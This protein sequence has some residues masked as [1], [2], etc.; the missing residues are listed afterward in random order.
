MK[1]LVTTILIGLISLLGSAQKVLERTI[2]CNKQALVFDLKFATEIEVK[3]CD[4]SSIYLKAEIAM[5]EEKYQ[6]MFQ[7]KVDERSSIIEIS[8]NSEAIFKKIWEVR[9]KELGKNQRYF[10]DHD[11]YT[12]HYLLYLPK[13][14][15][16]KI[17]SINGNMTSEIIEGDL[18]ADLIN[19]NISIA[20]Y[21]G[22]LDLSTINGE[23][24]LKVA[25]ASLTAETIHG[26][27]YADEKLK[28]KADD[29]MVGQKIE[30]S[31]LNATNRLKLNTINGNMY[32][33]L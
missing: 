33:R 26:N 13:N 22:N 27:I 5:E 21:S 30:G 18:T 24:D 9:E 15:R 25:N 23:I 17:S 1:N 4:K 3:T 8:D 28:F 7:V 31:T 20:A 12:I 16:Y 19:G 6:N 14:A 11:A 2:E 32:L 29:R 10:N